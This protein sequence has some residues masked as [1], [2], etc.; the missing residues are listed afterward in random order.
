MLQNV[1]LIPCGHR[2]TNDRRKDRAANMRNIDKGKLYIV[3]CA[4][5][6]KAPD[7]QG[8]KNYPNPIYGK[9]KIPSPDYRP[10]AISYWASPPGDKTGGRH[11]RRRFHEMPSG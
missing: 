1:P 8:S 6:W 5:S 4:R 10:S 7:N 9:N 2:S 11:I 3:A